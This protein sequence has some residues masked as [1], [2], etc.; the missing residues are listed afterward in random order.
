MPLQLS[1]LLL[2]MMTKLQPTPLSHRLRSGEV[3][4]MRWPTTLLMPLL[5]L[6]ILLL[7]SRRLDDAESF[8]FWRLSP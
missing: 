6:K 3:L 8:G 1:L 4:L 5:L 2:L 7:L